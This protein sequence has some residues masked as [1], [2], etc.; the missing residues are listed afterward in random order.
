MDKLDNVAVQIQEVYTRH[1]FPNKNEVGI[2][3]TQDDFKRMLEEF[4]IRRDDLYNKKILDAAC[5]TGVITALMAK[6]YNADVTGIDLS[7]ASID[8]AKKLC[9][10]MDIKS[11]VKF[12]NKSLMD[13]SEE[14]LP[15]QEYDV[16]ISKDTLNHVKDP[17]KCVKNLSLVLKKNGLLILRVSSLWQWLFDKA[18]VPYWKVFLLRRGLKDASTRVDFARKHKWYKKDVQEV[19][20]I[21][22]ETHL[23]DVFGTEKFG[24]F[25]YGE[26]LT[27][28]KSNELKYLFSQPSMEFNRLFLYLF[29]VKNENYK[30][31]KKRNTVLR[32][33]LFFIYRLLKIEKLGFLNKP[34]FLSRFLVQMVY[35]FPLLLERPIG[36]TVVARKE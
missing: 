8:I 10:R 16:I 29:Q 17:E 12:I 26:I 5:G 4:G 7:R 23:W 32:K 28:L 11:P 19:F 18:T 14:D 35:F 27:W 30:S 22:L 24:A 9:E 1:P 6:E 33:V 3:R 21:E 31:R 25:F 36:I 20:G 34:G 13:L 2:K 15:Y